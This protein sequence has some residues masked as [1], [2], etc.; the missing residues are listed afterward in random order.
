MHQPI[1]L[2][3]HPFNGEAFPCATFTIYLGVFPKREAIAW[4][5]DPDTAMVIAKALSQ[6]HKAGGVIVIK[7]KSTDTA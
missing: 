2:K 1:V 6:Y 5:N 7:G 3:A 4:A